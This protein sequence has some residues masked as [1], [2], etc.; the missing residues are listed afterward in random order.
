MEDNKRENISTITYVILLEFEDLKEVGTALFSLFLSLYVVTLCGNLL[1]ILAVQANPHLHTPMYFFLCHL[2][3]VDVGYTSSIAPQLL[4]EVLAGGVTISFT[5]CV[6]Q[7]YAVG[8]LL[9]VECF[10][11]AIMSYDCYLAICWPLRYSVL[12]DSRTCVKLAVGSWIGGFLFVGAVLIL[13]ATFTF[14]GPH[15][16]DDFFCDFFP[17]VKLSCSDT[18]MVERVA[19]ASSFL[20]LSPF[21]WTLL[22]Y[23]CILS[24]ILKISSSTG[25]YRAFSTCSSYLIV[26]SVFYG[27]MVVVYITPASGTTFNLSKIFSLLYTVVIPLLNPLIYSLRNKGVQIALKKGAKLHFSGGNHD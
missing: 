20:S 11:L 13:L 2:S 9:T 14:C 7:F 23:G 18:T 4:R 10:L 16:I 3:F 27:T 26:V 21:L 8:A 12:R 5:A 24:S 1:L 22:S 6:V 19:F 17:L 15:I 25:R